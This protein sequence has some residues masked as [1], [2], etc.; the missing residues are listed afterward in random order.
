MMINEMGREGRC[1]SRR[2]GLVWLVVLAMHG[3]AFAGGEAA[4]AD[5]CCDISKAGLMRSHLA[6]NE[7]ETL[8]AAEATHEEGEGQAADGKPAGEAPEGMVWIP[9]GEFTM[10]QEGL[11]PEEA[12]EHRVSVDG[13]WMAEH[14]V[15][16]LQFAEFIE[17]TGY[18]TVAERAPDP[19][20]FPGVPPELLVPGSVVFVQPEAADPQGN[21]SQWWQWMPGATWNKPEGPGSSIEDRMDHPVVHVAYEDAVAYVE[22]AGGQLPTEAQW[23]RAARGGLEGKLYIWGNEFKPE[24]EHMANTWQGKFPVENTEEDGFAGS[25]P[26][27][28]FPPN[29]YGLY[30]MAGNVW[31]WTSTWYNLAYYRTADGKHNPQGPPREESHDPREPGTPKLVIRGGSFLCAPNYCYRYRPAARSAG[32]LDTG[33]SHQGFRLVIVPS[34]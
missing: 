7:E 11:Y 19:A 20:D 1:A 4:E 30:D 27:K 9:G 10:G 12:P 8:V 28:S 2:K 34:S 16:N 32:D 29:G 18:E 23:E 15:T 21:I 6:A 3:V 14:P 22:W 31:E 33:T 25:S 24:G 13:F 5:D 17:E 26:V